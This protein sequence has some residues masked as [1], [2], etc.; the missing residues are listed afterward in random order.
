[1]GW[2]RGKNGKERLT[3]RADALRVEGRRIRGRSNL[4]WGG[5]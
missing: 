1:M 2:T 4:R 3:K 5:L